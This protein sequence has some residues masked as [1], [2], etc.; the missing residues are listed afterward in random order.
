[1]KKLFIICSLLVLISIVE[2]VAQTSNWKYLRSSNTGVG[3]DFIQTI[4]VDRFGN[5]W[6]GG[7][8]PFWSEGSVARFNDTVWTNWSNFEGYLP[9]DRVYDVAFDNNDGLWVATNGVGNN[10]AH[11]GISHYDGITWTSYTTA[12]SPLPGDDMRGICVD[13]NNNVWATFYSV[14]SGLGGVSKFDGTS[15][16]IYTPS[17]SNLQSGQ[18]DKIDVD[19]Q[20][21]IWI[22]SNLGLIKFDGLNWILFTSTN[23][24]LTNNNVT[25][26]EYDESTNKIYAATGAAVD[27][28][29]GSNWT[30]FN[31]G[32]SPLS[33]SGIWS[34]D[35]RGDS[36]IVTTVG[37]SYLTYVFDG[38]SWITHPESDHTYD[39]RIDL[40]GN[41][42]ICGIGFIEKYD[43]VSWT[44]YTRYNTGLTTYFIDRL[45]IDSK[46]RKWFGTS[47]NGGMSM[48]DCP[49]WEDYGLYNNGLWPMPLTLGNNGTSATE[50]IYGN[51]WMS[52]YAGGIVKIPNGDVHNS[53]AWVSWQAS[54]VPNATCQIIAADSSGDVWA[55]GGCG[56]AIQYDHSTGNWIQH[57]LYNMG[58]PCGNNNYMYNIK[59]NPNNNQVW[60]CTQAGIAIYDAGTWTIKSQLNGGLPFQNTYYDVVFDSQNNAWIASDSGLIKMT[61]NTWTI[62]NESNSSLIAN[63]ISS[64]AIDTADNIYMTSYNY[65][66]PYYGGLNIFDGGTNWQT[67]N[68]YST[69]IPHHQIATVAL[70]K[71]GNVWITTLVYGAVI[72]NP[73]GVQGWDCIDTTLQMGGATGIQLTELSGTNNISVS[74]NPFSSTTSLEFNLSESKKV[75]ISITDV[76]GKI[77]KTIP[78]K[79]LLSGKNIIEI[80]LSELNS[81]IYFCQIKSSENT[82]TFKLIK[83]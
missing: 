34:V 29:D 1:M 43:G 8:M 7:Y 52:Y 10:V 21:N 38:T 30:H 66:T 2:T 28:Y 80:N 58:L 78:T 5:K 46:N 62:Y 83:N 59:T 48:F 71:L 31:S 42:W 51:I 70:D 50:D 25:D 73:N 76:I 61:G 72:Y 20:N 74:P 67:F 63:H 44:R 57:N 18:V 55:E 64:L 17:N 47:D 32:N 77:V 24:G 65:S 49:V 60:F 33:S 3:G 11:G 45:F 9:A 35:A 23:S 26:V 14:T 16:T 68:A 36:I 12:N 6:S 37:G 15:W 56:L 69:P 13:H 41:F 53:A 40:D 82:K 19:L 39:S 22:G 27:I 75:S 4:E 54:A 79:N 81:G